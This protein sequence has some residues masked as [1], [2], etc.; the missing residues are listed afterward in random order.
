MSNTLLYDSRPF[1]KFMESN[2]ETKIM[3]SSLM[4]TSFNPNIS[5]YRESMIE[6]NKNI[7]IGAN[8]INLVSDKSKIIIT[9][10]SSLYHFLTDCL[11]ASAAIYNN[12]KNI[13]IIVDVTHVQRNEN[14]WKI[15]ESMIKFLLKCFDYHK[16]SY[17]VVNFDKIDYLVLN[18]FVLDAIIPNVLIHTDDMF[19]FIKPLI[20]DLNTVPNKKIYLSRRKIFNSDRDFSTAG[21]HQKI[22]KQMQEDNLVFPHFDDNRIYDEKVLEDFFIKN[23]FE[24]CYPEDFKSFEDQ[25]NFMYSV[26]TLA[27][28]TSSGISNS[29]FMQ[30]NGNMIEILTTLTL[31]EMSFDSDIPTVKHLKNEIHHFYHTISYM[32]KHSYIAVPNHTRL[33]KDIINLLSK[34]ELFGSFFH[35]E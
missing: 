3:D 2:P 5:F 35:N 15:S 28:V 18:N 21:D 8:V 17:T 19:N 6:Y 29:F 1:L 24:I 34:N 13:H 26:K 9:S 22:I 16:I 14:I 31:G 30:N 32:K 23:G 11:M 4:K 10:S 12:L 25:V 7:L 27:S 20:K 33:S